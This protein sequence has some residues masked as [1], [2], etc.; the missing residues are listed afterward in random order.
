MWLEGFPY[1]QQDEFARRRHWAGF[2]WQD[3]DV[4]WWLPVTVLT[5]HGIADKS[6]S[7]PG[8]SNS[9]DVKVICDSVSDELAPK[10]RKA[11]YCSRTKPQQLTQKQTAR[12]Q[13]CRSLQSL[14]EE[15]EAELRSVQHE[16]VSKQS[17]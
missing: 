17:R 16:R 1:I 11:A 7:L 3:W 4:D 10:H 2:L 15:E 8:N 5:L 6:S 14:E 9:N 12:L 13:E